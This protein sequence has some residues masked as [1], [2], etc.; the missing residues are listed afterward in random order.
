MRCSA[1]ASII[2]AAA[3]V[4]GSAACNRPAAAPARARDEKIEKPR[5][6]PNTRE[7]ETDKIARGKRSR[8]LTRV[9]AWVSGLEGDKKRIYERYG[10]PTSRIRQ[11]SMG[12]V[13]EKWTYSGTGK[14]FTFKGNRLVR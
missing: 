5:D 7:V 3:L 14:T 2:L 4:L 11:E 8:R 1:S 12:S 6:N 13:V 10:H 9:D